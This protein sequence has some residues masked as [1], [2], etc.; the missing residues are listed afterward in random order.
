[1]AW[2]EVRQN[3]YLF[4]ICRWP[5]WENLCASSFPRSPEWQETAEMGNFLVVQWLGR[6]AFTAGAWVQSL[7][8]EL[9]FPKPQDMAKNKDQK[10]DRNLWVD[11]TGGA[12]GLWNPKSVPEEINKFLFSY[13][14]LLTPTEI[15]RIQCF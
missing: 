10:W 3:S 1:M 12:I 6:C 5:Y 8:R 7:I 11:N 4:M 14:C 13:C 2:L 9:S 15:L